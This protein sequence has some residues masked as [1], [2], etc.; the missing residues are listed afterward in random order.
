MF[1]TAL[2]NKLTAN[3]T[4]EDPVTLYK[5][6]N[7][8]TSNITVDSDLDNFKTMSSIAGAVGTINKKYM[9]YITAPYVL[10]SPGEFSYD[11]AGNHSSP[12]PGFDQLW[13][14]MRNDQPLPGSPAAAEFG[15]SSSTATATPSPASSAS[16][17]ADP[18]P[19]VALKDVTVQ[20]D[21]GTD[22]S[23]EARHA[24]TYLT[25]LGITASIGNGGYSGYSA[26]TV[27]Y[28]AGDQAAADTVAN[29]VAGAVVKESSNVS[30]VTLVIGEQRA[31]RGRR[32]VVGL[33]VHDRFRLADREHQRRGPERRREHL[34]RPAGRPVRRPPLG[35]GGPGGRGGGRRISAR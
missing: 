9:Q 26:T 17:S 15:T 2:F 29:Q 23:G 8:V 21:N 4:L 32:L 7:A 19:T 14:D 30:A 22:I 27:Y 20:V 34:L 16:A 25:G 31:A 5:I 18:S 13:T 11:E 35:R 10:D 28:P 33:R 3:G 24:V 1:M 12:G 6:A